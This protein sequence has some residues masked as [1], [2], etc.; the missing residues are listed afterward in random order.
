MK[1]RLKGETGVLGGSPVEIVTLMWQG[2][3]AGGD[4]GLVG[5][6]KWSMSRIAELTG[7]ALGVETEGRA[8]E[9]IAED[10]LRALIVRGL[11]DEVA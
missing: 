3:W 4:L 8:K 9:E 6:M 10:Y 1:I 2:S 11:A 5:Y 7:R